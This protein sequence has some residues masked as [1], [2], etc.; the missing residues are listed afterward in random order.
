MRLLAVLS[1]VSALGLTGAAQAAPAEPPG[2]DAGVI[3]GSA[4]R[5]VAN[6]YIVVLKRKKAARPR[7]IGQSS[8]DL[9]GRHGGRVKR[10]YSAALHGFEMAMSEQE[11][12]RFARDP[13]VAYVERNER[14]A[15]VDIQRDP[16]WG[17]DRIDG[18]G[19]TLDGMYYHTG[20]ASAVHA[21]VIDTGIRT[22]HE[23]FGGRAVLGFD[24][25][26]HEPDSGDCAGHGTHVAGTLGGRDYGVAKDVQ[27]VA[28]RILDCD[29]NG[30][31]A[32]V[33]A[34][35]DWVTAHA[36][37]PAVANL[38]LGGIFHVQSVDDAVQASIASGVTYAVAAGNHH[39][40]ACGESPASVVEAITIAATE[41]ND[42]PAWFSNYGPCVDLYAPG[43]DIDSAGNASDTAHLKMYGTSMASPHVAG[44]AALVL[45]QHPDWTPGQVRDALVE[46]A[47]PDGVRL[48]E[49]GTTSRL[50][51]T[52]APPKDFAVSVFPDSASVLAGEHATVRVD[53]PLTTEAGQRVRLTALGAPQYVNLSFAP[54]D[55]DVWEHRYSDL[56]IDVD[57]RAAAQTAPITI[58]AEGTDAT[59]TTTF[60]LT[61]LPPR[62]A[63]SVGAP[64]VS[65]RV[66]TAAV[67]TL[68]ADA[69]AGKP[70][71]I[72]LVASGLP[73]GVVV[74]GLDL[75]WVN[76]P[77]EIRF[78][79]PPGVAPG[80]YPVTITGTA[81]AT[82]STVVN[83]T[84][85]GDAGTCGQLDEPWLAVMPAAT[86]DLTFTVSNCD[87][88]G[89]ADSLVSLRGYNVSGE[90][91]TQMAFE[92]IAPDGAVHVLK[93][94]GTASNGD[95]Y[96][97]TYHVDLSGVPANGTWRLR[98]RNTMP[99][100][101]D[102]FFQLEDWM[103]TI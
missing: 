65:V 24:A 59:H 102:D 81:E 80:T 15:A 32:T 61:V 36:V 83:L 66:G 60:T 67:T 89:S 101:A 44:A 11:A 103:V 40:D 92:L 39:V 30:D 78:M 25:T 58:R 57:G 43:V 84:V 1:M 46:T 74:R 8:A 29:G 62:F 18:R 5:A 76:D 19:R 49:T 64:E 71:L 14:I 79:I 41:Q 77:R 6:S 3:R 2:A 48:P 38:S 68:R 70:G 7:A 54:V 16:P 86:E 56:T 26:Q 50:L 100:G 27:L 85:T 98:V 90:L 47:T 99:A 55:V 87:R 95:G 28:V 63:L 75:I 72:H 34:G 13:D 23:T 45:A 88:R 37:K 73:S 35:I 4:E 94:A 17:L 10:T 51:F 69:V 53:L 42:Y 20:S 22:S 21:Y 82:A 9:A 33:I 31:N 52:G 93:P 91:D 96:D 97:R 12:L